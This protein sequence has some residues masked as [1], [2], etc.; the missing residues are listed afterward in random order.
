MGND[1]KLINMWKCIRIKG[2]WQ[3]VIC[4]NELYRAWSI[5]PSVRIAYIKEKMKYSYFHNF[6]ISFDWLYF[7]IKIKHLSQ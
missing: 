4:T 3:L 7:G 1:K 2:K 5:L 6:W